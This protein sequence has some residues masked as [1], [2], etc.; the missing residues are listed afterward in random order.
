MARASHLSH[1]CSSRFSEIDDDSG[2]GIFFLNSCDSFSSGFSGCL[3]DYYRLR[4]VDG[5]E[6]A[7]RII[8]CLQCSSGGEKDLVQ[9]FS[10]FVWLGLLT[11]LISDQFCGVRET[12]GRRLIHSRTVRCSRILCC[13]PKEEATIFHQIRQSSGRYKWVTTMERKQVSTAASV[14]EKSV[15]QA[16]RKNMKRTSRFVLSVT[17]LTAGALL[18]AEGRG[19]MFM[20]K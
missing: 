19:E 13:E 17:V 9:H 8:T 7:E 6:V 20:G 5:H 16:R 12:K 10:C 3:F 1:T 4:G 11:S 18:P 2:G 15:T 14:P